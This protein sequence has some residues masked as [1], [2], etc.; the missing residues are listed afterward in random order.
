MKAVVDRAS[1]LRAARRWRVLGVSLAVIIAGAWLVAAW[2]AAPVPLT[3]P[4]LPDPNG[5]DDVLRA[6]LA[7]QN[8]GANFDKVDV[9]TADETALIP[10]VE[11]NRDALAMARRG[12]DRPFQVPV[13]HDLNELN[14]Q[15]PE[16][17]AIRESARAL[18]AEGR[19]AEHQDRLDDAVRAYLDV[20]RLGDAMSHRVA[21]IAHQMGRFIEYLGLSGLRDLRT[22]LTADEVRRLIGTLQALARE[23]EAVAAVIRREH[24]FMDSNVNKMGLGMRV[25]YPLSGAL[26]K[27][28]ARAMSMLTQNDRRAELFH[29][30]LLADLAVRLYQLEHGTAPA[31][32]DALSPAILESVPIDPYSGKPLIYRKSLEGF[33]LYS[34]GP[35]GIDDHLGPVLGKRHLESSKG[36]LTLD[37]F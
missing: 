36:D 1:R 33:Q 22:H 25:M 30:L 26:G 4:P 34:V 29:H 20:V 14:R 28:K 5:Y 7:I 18:L 9:T 32:L 10:L 11:A 12:L 15:M 23:R 2:L 21:M 17:S 37:S 24:Q 8:G 16:F 13:V 35:D 6:G 3:S 27:E 19:L 31:S